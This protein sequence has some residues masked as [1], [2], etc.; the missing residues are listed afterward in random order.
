MSFVRKFSPGP[1]NTGED[2][3]VAGAVA[4]AVDTATDLSW[5]RVCL[6]K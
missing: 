6:C 5:V 4:E 1:I 2:L 3:R